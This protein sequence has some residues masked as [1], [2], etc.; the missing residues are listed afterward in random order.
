MS[1]LQHSQKVNN[2][3]YTH[4][5]NNKRLFGKRILE[6]RLMAKY[7]EARLETKMLHHCYVYF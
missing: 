6:I 5:K 3:N 2:K 4:Y 1:K 7:Y